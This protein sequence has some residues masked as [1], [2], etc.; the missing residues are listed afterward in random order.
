MNDKKI[1][2]I[3]CTNDEREL[4]E[5][6]GYLDRL[7]VPQGYEKDVIAVSEAPSMAEGYNAGMQSTDAKY[8]VYMHQDVFI[9]NPNFI[10]DMVAVFEDRQVG[11]LGMVGTRKMPADAY[12]VA[13]WDTGKV[14]HN[15]LYNY[16]GYQNVRRKYVE[17]EAVDGL[18]LATQYDVQ[19]REDLFREWDFYDISLAFEFRRKGY[20]VVVP[21][22]EKS[23]VF[24]NNKYS[25]MLNYDKNRLI[26]AKEYSRD[27]NIQK[28][29][30]ARPVQELELLKS[31]AVEYYTTLIKSGKIEQVCTELLG[32]TSSSFLCFRDIRILAEIYQKETQKSIFEWK[33]GGEKLFEQLN[34]LKWFL[35]R[36]E[37]EVEMPQ[38]EFRYYGDNY[39]VWAFFYVCMNYVVK[40]KMVMQCLRSYLQEPEIAELLIKRLDDDMGFVNIIKNSGI[41][42]IRNGALIK[43]KRRILVI[44]D[45]SN[46]SERSVL[47]TDVII[48]KEDIKKLE[49]YVSKNIPVI[50][51]AYENQIRQAVLLCLM[52]CDWK[53]DTVALYAKDK[54]AGKIRSLLEGT[55]ITCSDNEWPKTS[56]VILSY[57]TLNITKECIE[58]IRENLPKDEYELIIVDNAS[59][60]GSA[61]YLKQ[62]SDIKLICNTENK[63]FAGGCNQGIALAQEG[64]DIWL[65]NS[66]T[67]VPKQA[68]F[69]LKVGLYSGAN[70][71]ACGSVSNFCPNYQNIIETNVN[72]E[73]YQ[74]VAKQYNHYMEDAL[75]KKNWLVGFS[76]L[77]KRE[78]L[79]RTGLLDERF[80]PGNFEDNDLS[81]RLIQAGYQLM[82]CHNS[83]VFHYGSLSFKKGNTIS[84]SLVEN[85][86]R[87]I[88]KW[89]FDPERYTAIKTRHIGMLKE[90]VNSEFSVLD[91]GAG[92]GATINR[93]KYLYPCVY[94]AGIEENKVV[95]K[96][97]ADNGCTM[98]LD[99]I[100]KFDYVF[101]D[102]IE[103]S[104]LCLIDEHI[105]EHG[106]IIGNC[107]NRYYKELCEDDV[108]NAYSGEEMINA[109]TQ[110]GYEVVELSYEKGKL[111][112]QEKVSLLCSK[113]GCDK[114][115][116]EAETF[117]FVARHGGR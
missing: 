16:N 57:N 13:A 104:I 75:E 92:V 9:V 28:E 23:W 107:Y 53:I 63:G 89:G 67:L 38:E 49:E 69:G 71:G 10:A 61:E 8:K 109:L 6:L 35:K 65:L 114:T 112:E 108:Q 12:A 70:I 97:A 17:V 95:A 31:E 78:A 3:L 18:L 87:F 58:S 91:I 88:E 4:N 59:S 29:P 115:L 74:Q 54:T 62:Q 42:T 101:I 37:Y 80:F 48:A 30:E 19:F 85:K 96:I 2:F 51:C 64:N 14:C 25:K 44:E 72:K 50:A 55:N 1:A 52:E 113:Y 83:F 41:Y 81:Y 102:G 26:F 60:D 76:M 66:D 20:K 94:V 99:N 103:D 68:L 21:Y 79:D 27:F 105:K 56:I 45:V 116:V 24:H 11:L 32:S 5:C 90:D 22:Q 77:I 15:E 100:K 43:G 33:N 84:P 106:K 34:E 7:I 46:L 98:N 86:K 111:I 73:H 36:V 117:Y 40:K 39:S 93:V 110:R 82:L 47:P